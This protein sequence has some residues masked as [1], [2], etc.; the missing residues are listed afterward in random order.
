MAMSALAPMRGRAKRRAG[1]RST[2]ERA[3]SREL[4][5]SS[6]EDT[7]VE[8]RCVDDTGAPHSLDYIVTATT[9]RI[10]Q[11][12]FDE[13]FRTQSP[14]QRPRQ[15]QIYRR[16]GAGA[17]AGRLRALRGDR[18][19]DPARRAPLLERRAAGGLYRRSDFS[20]ALSRHPLR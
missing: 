12:R 5:S 2:A 13:P 18:A 1:A 19:L 20:Q 9:Q 6:D 8:D 16:R 15:A 11:L 3:T 4:C 10:E 7:R 17:L 14:L